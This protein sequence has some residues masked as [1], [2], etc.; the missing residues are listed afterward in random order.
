MSAT[1][2]NLITATPGDI[3]DVIVFQFRWDGVP[4]E[5]FAVLLS[6]GSWVAYE[7][8]CKHLPLTLDYGDHQFLNSTKDRIVC[9]T[10][11]AEY[12]IQDGKCV[13]GPCVGATLSKLPLHEDSDGLFLVGEAFDR[14][15][16]L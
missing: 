10:H 16:L 13:A 1:F 11:G 8:R 7:N 2:R 4:R 9:Q 12:L 5:G 6:D 3:G 15:Q 14:V